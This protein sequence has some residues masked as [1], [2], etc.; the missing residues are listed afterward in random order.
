[1]LSVA[2][3]QHAAGGGAGIGDRR[4]RPNPI[5]L[6][7]IRSE[8]DKPPLPVKSNIC[9]PNVDEWSR[10]N[11]PVGPPN[12]TDPESAAAS[13][14]EAPVPIVADPSAPIAS[15]SVRWVPAGTLTAST[16]N[17]LVQRWTVLRT[18][19]VDVRPYIRRAAV[20]IPFPEIRADQ[21]RT[22]G[23][24]PRLEKCLIEFGLQRRV[25]TISRCGR[26][27]A[28]LVRNK[29]RFHG[30]QTPASMPRAAE[31]NMPDSIANTIPATYAV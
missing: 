30:V 24:G 11:I 27:A 26:S 2:N 29:G 22:L 31:V 6:R 15:L 12:F 16:G 10:I 5:S 9:P 14:S 17:S 3:C 4:S 18:E 28:A 20:R 19:A 8:P 21:G 7:S 23:L 1:M 13:S 25:R